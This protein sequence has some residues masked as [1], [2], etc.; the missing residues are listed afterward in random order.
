MPQTFGE[1]LRELR[2]TR[3]MSQSELA[4]AVLGKAIR[5]GE[6][7]KWEGGKNEP[8]HAYLIRLAQFFNVSVDELL[9]VTSIKSPPSS[10]TQEVAPV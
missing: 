6:I 9:G 2:I 3:G 4:E 10:P 1:R 8:S 7:S 5:A